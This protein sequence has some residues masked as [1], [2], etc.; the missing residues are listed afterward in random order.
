MKTY[1][2]PDFELV[3]FTSED[4]AAVGGGNVSGEG[5]EDMD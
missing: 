5:N 2:T 4:I 3:K 1:M